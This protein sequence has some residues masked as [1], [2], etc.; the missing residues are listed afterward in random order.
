MKIISGFYLFTLFYSILSQ[1][2]SHS[3]HPSVN[4]VPDLATLLSMS[5]MQNPAD[6]AMLTQLF[7][8]YSG[9][10]VTS[11]EEMHNQLKR[12]MEKSPSSLPID[13]KVLPMCGLDVPSFFPS[14][15]TC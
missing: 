3:Q 9:P 14:E 11:E 6:L 13:P 10:P 15:Y 5:N 2:Q 1:G 8:G 4:Q 12:A 7:S